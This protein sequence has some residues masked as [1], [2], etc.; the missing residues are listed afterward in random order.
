M[1]ERT[2]FDR[3][4]HF[5]NL[6]KTPVCW[7]IFRKH[8]EVDL[9]ELKRIQDKISKRG[10]LDDIDL[11]SVL[12]TY[13][14][15]TAFSIFARENKFHERMLIQM[16][17]GEFEDEMQEDESYLENSLL[18][19]LFRI[20]NLPTPDMKPEAAKAKKEIIADN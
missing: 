1:T 19:R 13:N 7:A 5:D 18:R 10:R 4:L 2:N 3:F 20:L 15:H 16:Q 14:G 17:E 8:A 12:S 6:P 9:Q 11:Q